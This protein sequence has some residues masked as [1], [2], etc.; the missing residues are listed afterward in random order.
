MTLSIASSAKWVVF[1][2]ED[3]GVGMGEPLVP[4]VGMHSMCERAEEFGGTTVFG[5]SPALG[6]LKVTTSIPRAVAQP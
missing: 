4:G 3:D 5:R 1:T 6:G 2:V